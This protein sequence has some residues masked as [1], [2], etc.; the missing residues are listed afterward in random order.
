MRHPQVVVYESDGWL[1]G[2]LEELAGEN[3]WLL[4]QSRDPGACVNLLA[5]GGPSLLMLKLERNL[6]GELTL[7]ADLRE[8]APDCPAVVVSDVKLDAE[9]RLTLAGLAYDLG[10]RCVLFPPLTQTLL[11]DVVSGLMEAT[12]R[13][14][15]GT[16]TTPAGKRADSPLPREDDA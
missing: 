15:V 2:Q 13:R 3:A 12:I 16:G 8:R 5:Q 7:L 6:V 14:V 10:A 4:R 1:A 9:Q 11:E